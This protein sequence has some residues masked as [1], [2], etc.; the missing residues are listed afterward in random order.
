GKPMLHLQL[1]NWYANF[2]PSAQGL[3]ANRV[4][5]VYRL[6]MVFSIP[7]GVKNLQAFFGYAGTT[8]AVIAAFWIVFTK[9]PGPFTAYAVIF[10]NAEDGIFVF[11]FKS[12][13]DFAFSVGPKT[14]FDGIFH[15]GLNNH[16]GHP[17]DVLFY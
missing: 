9:L 7:M 2:H 14:V 16:G 8:R 10:Y 17:H 3:A 4:H 15:I 12:Q 1:H 5:E 6:Y 13:R 11:Q